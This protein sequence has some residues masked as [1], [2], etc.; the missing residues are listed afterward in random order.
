MNGVVRGCVFACVSGQFSKLLY[1]WSEF[2]AVAV[3]VEGMETQLDCT[4]SD[5]PILGCYWSEGL[6]RSSPDPAEGIN[7]RANPTA[8]SVYS[9][10]SYGRGRQPPRAPTG[11]HPQ[12][13]NGVVVFLGFRRLQIQT[14][15]FSCSLP[16]KVGIPQQDN[17]LNYI[18]V[19]G[20]D[21]PPS[22]MGSI[23][24]YLVKETNSGGH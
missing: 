11:T 12:L 22:T 23:E 6:H 1:Y 21:G 5:S 13:Y 15:L 24:L 9:K 19:L 16:A 18:L 8:E 17:K 7:Q 2:I 4:G 3:A 14:F 20:G 10:L